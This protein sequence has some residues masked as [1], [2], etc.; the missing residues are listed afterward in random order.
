MSNVSGFTEVE[1]VKTYIMSTADPLGVAAA[2]HKAIMA[3]FILAD[4]TMI[5]Y[6]PERAGGP[7]VPITD[8]CGRGNV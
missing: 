7:W 6:K 8:T 2:K 1:T 3:C 4:G 5:W